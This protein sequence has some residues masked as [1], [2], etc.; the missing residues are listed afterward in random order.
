MLLTKVCRSYAKSVYGIGRSVY[1]VALFLDM[2]D[3]YVTFRK[4]NFKFGTMREEEFR[5]EFPI[6][7]A[8]PGGE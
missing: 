7:L 6:R 4:K 1:V 2:G 3:Y 8:V 5:K